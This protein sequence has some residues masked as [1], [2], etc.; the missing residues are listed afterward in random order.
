MGRE[1]KSVAEMISE[2]LR[3]A[4]VLVGVFVPMDMVF[5]EKPIPRTVLGF[6]AFIFVLCFTVGVA[7]E[8]V[9]KP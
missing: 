3:E 9:K 5:S 8:T 7:I 2:L 6:G 4:A 1:K